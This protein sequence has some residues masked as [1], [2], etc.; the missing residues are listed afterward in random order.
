MFSLM[1]GGRLKVR[2]FTYNHIVRYCSGIDIN[3]GCPQKW[4]MAEGY[5][6]HLLKNPDLVS[7][8]GKGKRK[9]SRAK[10]RGNG[11]FD[12]SQICD[13]VQQCTIRSNLPTSIKIRVDTDMR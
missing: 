1:V 3:C 13:M 2:A 4:A 9:E 7:Q 6:S 8:G 12:T 5:G 10:R 11:V